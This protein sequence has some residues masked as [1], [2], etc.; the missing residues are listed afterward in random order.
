LCKLTGAQLKIREALL[1]LEAIRTSNEAIDYLSLFSWGQE[2]SQHANHIFPF[3]SNLCRDERRIMPRTKERKPSIIEGCK[4]GIKNCSM[5]RK[6]NKK[7]SIIPSEIIV[8]NITTNT[9][10]LSTQSK[11]RKASS[12]TAKCSKVSTRSKRREKDGMRSTTKP[13]QVDVKTENNDDDD[14]GITLDDLKCSVCLFGDCTDENDVILCDGKDCHRAFH[15]KCVYP[16][17]KGE[18]IENEHDDWFCPICAS[19]A[20]F[21]GEMHDLCIGDDD[22]DDNSSGSWTDVHDIFPNS[23]WQNQTAVKILKGK[24][25]DDTQRL[26]AM[27]FGEDVN[28]NQVQML[29]GSDSEDENDYSLFDEDSFEERRHREREEEDDGDS[30]KDDST[31][32]SQATLQGKSSI[33]YKV[34]KNELAALSEDEDECFVENNDEESET[35]TRRSRRLLKRKDTVEE[36]NCADVGADFSEAN[37][38]NGKRKRRRVNYRKLND[39]MFG[40]LSDHQQVMIDGGDDFDDSKIKVTKTESDND[41]DDHDA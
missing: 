13:A 29:V 4:Q 2:Y 7:D 37:I 25:N 8:N 33:E 5:S 38:V 12:A 20:N 24:R 10:T 6:S 30:N 19:I 22:D 15:M 9:V 40:D 28:K 11:E 23:K 26:V 34:G 27:F 31:C 36:S 17:V 14:S 1:S 39:M 3:G 18:D 21:M 35:N 32:S 16:I 41:S